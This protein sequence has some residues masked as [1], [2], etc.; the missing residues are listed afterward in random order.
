MNWIPKDP[1][2][3]IDIKYKLPLGFVCLYLF[4][5]GIGGYFVI[6]SVYAPLNQEILFRLQSESL[7]Q[8]TIFDKKLETL[9]RRVEDFA[10]DG[11]IRTQTKIQLE[12]PNQTRSLEE[13]KRHL[14]LNKLSLVTEFADLQ[15]YDLKGERII[16]VKDFSFQFEKNVNSDLPKSGQK[17]SS[18]IAPN[19]KNTFPATAIITPIWDIH[20]ENQIGYLI[21]IVNLI[22]VIN[23]TSLDY[24]GNLDESK[25]EKYLTFVD[26]K[27]VAL[28][29]P[30]WFL[31]RLD[32]IQN[33]QNEDEVIGIKVISAK[34]ENSVTHVG[35]HTCKNGKEM[36][37]QS[38]PLKSAGWNTL[39][40]LDAKDALIPLQVMEG[41]L[42]GVA[43]A[44]ALTTLILLFFPIQYL[45]RPLSELQKMAFFIKEGD[46]S[47]RNKI[48]SE[49]EIGQLA[50]TFNLMT[51]AI[52]ERTTNLEKI[53]NDLESRERE[54]RIQ[55]NR[56]QTVVNSMRDGLILLNSKG[57]ISLSNEAAEPIIDKLGVVEAQLGI[58]TCQN[59][60]QDS[61]KCLNC[62]FDPFKVSSCELKS[63]DRIYEF[64]SS[65]LPSLGGNSGKVLVV[66]DITE[67]EL[68]KEQQAHQER[69]AVLGRTAAVVAHEMNNPLAAISM[70]N[71]MMEEELPKGSPFLEHVEVINRNTDTCRQIIRELLDY[72]RTPQPKAEEVDLQIVVN[73]S[74]RLL[75][76]LYSKKKII[77]EEV[78]E[79]EDT[80]IWGDSTQLQQVFVNLLD[81]AIQSINSREVNICIRIGK[82][83][84]ENQ[85]FVEVKD[86][87]AGIPLELQREIFE[88][89]FTTKS[90]GGTGLGLPTAK[91][92]IT[93]H[94]GDLTLV[95]SQKGET[96]FRVVLP[97]QEIQTTNFETD[98]LKV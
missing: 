21:C 55:H 50:K 10:S 20:M 61:E 38:Y 89:F 32:P 9:V 33:W 69:L 47:K 8:A 41:K 3:K 30:W 94:S 35:R 88:P 51:D 64:I 25:I 17:L 84:S 63:N 80:L 23:N 24:Q 87:G 4:V 7:A 67:R 28:E 76:S 95:K 1:L 6:N 66:R 75:T 71:Q 44:V 15:I 40:E 96:I 97:L 22:S 57:E 31:K 36:F 34:E 39:I 11:F 5:F 52:E 85:V 54:L 90:S 45:V 59:H 93:A 27:G 43:L 18:I 26:S 58:K 42:F 91:R 60:E 68:M 37:G 53:A 29:V 83:T 62:L 82:L 86:N 79:T 81:N 98:P 49:D 74:V 19:E 46:F 92:I 77:I 12:N 2:S 78:L 73:N 14:L 13:L 70:Y 72:A 48:S 16:S 65:K 56:L